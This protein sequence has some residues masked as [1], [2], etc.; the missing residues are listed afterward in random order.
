MRRR[1][2]QSLV[3]LAA[4]LAVLALWGCFNNPPVN[5]AEL[6]FAEAVLAN[7]WFFS[8]LIITA[9]PTATIPALIEA[10]VEGTFY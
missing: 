9:T 3:G 7:S 4:I 1:A 5:P 6:N 8:S 10:I 2:G